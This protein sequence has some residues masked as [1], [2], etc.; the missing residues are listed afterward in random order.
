MREDKREGGVL[1]GIYLTISTNKLKED[2]DILVIQ[3]E[4]DNILV[5]FDLLLVSH[6]I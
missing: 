3:F 4:D 6:D 2:L 1:V 5:L